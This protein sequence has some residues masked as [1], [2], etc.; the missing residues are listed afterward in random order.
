MRILLIAYA[1]EPGAGSEPGT[2]WNIALELSRKFDVTVIT[3]CN[4]RHAIESDTQ[5]QARGRLNFIYHDAS[6]WELWL[7][8]KKLISTQIYYA[9]W[10]R[11]LGRRIKTDQA[12]QN[13]DVSQHLTFNSFEV[14]PHALKHT[15]G[16]KIWGPVG[17]GQTAPASL[18]KTT[19]L[20]DR[21]REKLRTWRV[22]ISSRSESVRTMLESC[23]VVLFAN[24]ETRARLEPWCTGKT[25]MM[26]DVG[27]A[28]ERFFPSAET[29]N[30]TRILCAGRIESRKG[31]GLLLESFKLALTERPELRL[32]IIGTGPNLD[33]EQ[34]RAQNLCIQGQ[35]EFV[36][37]VDHAQMEEELRQ[38]DMFVFPSLRDTSGAVVL[39]AM[40]SGI[41]V[42]CLDHQG[43]RLMTGDVSGIRVP[44]TSL[45]KT[46]K[47]FAKAIV[48]LSLDPERRQRCAKSARAR[49][50]DEFSWPRKADRLSRI[51]SLTRC[52]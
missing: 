7:K 1:C 4:N 14:A 18:L 36:G 6:S 42:I 24:E 40:A 19:R 46:K 52:E 13:F 9:L 12:L 43:G 31:I 34:E 15:S 16:M 50:I 28:P 25:E 38:A 49:V 17:G 3:R 45:E 27:V 41:P 33:A 2:G 51:Y 44:V 11:T 35:V 47:D 21:W 39:E 10:Q 48:D 26:I 30:G 29:S 23:D 37:K 22:G 20:Q 32:R 5:R 8:K